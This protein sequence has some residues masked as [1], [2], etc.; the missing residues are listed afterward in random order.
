MTKYPVTKKTRSL[1]TDL[2][3]CRTSGKWTE[4]AF[5]VMGSHRRVGM[6]T[7]R[8]SVKSGVFNGKKTKTLFEPREFTNTILLS[9]FRLPLTILFYP[10]F[11]CEDVD[12]SS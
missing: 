3:Q 5:I 10:R 4:S 7:D 11:S 9:E 8:V 2:I 6:S 1:Q 12:L